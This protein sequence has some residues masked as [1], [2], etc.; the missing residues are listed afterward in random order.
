M[1]GDVHVLQDWTSRM[2]NQA[3]V[4]SVISY[5]RTAKGDVQW[6]SDITADAVTMVNTK[7]ELEPQATLFEELDLTLHVLKSTENLSFDHIRKVG[8]EPAFT[9][10]APAQIVTDYLTMVAKCEGK[11]KAINVE[12]LARTNTPVDIVITVPVVSRFSPTSVKDPLRLL[13]E[14]VL[15]G[16][17]LHLQG[18]QRGWLQQNC[19]PNTARHYFGDRARSCLLLYS[20]RS[21]REW[22]RVL[23]GMRD[24]HTL[25]F[26]I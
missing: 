4:P 20:S 17:R 26:D 14:L 8:P 6:G 16:L 5:V 3:K 12:Q 11:R 9:S 7:L 25:C 23:E 15:Q 21:S 22:H 10:R 18:Y 13:A 2:N 24:S 1:L 19:V